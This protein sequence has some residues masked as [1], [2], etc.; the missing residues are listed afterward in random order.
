MQHNPLRFERIIDKINNL[1]V[2]QRD[3]YLKLKNDGLYK[4][5][6]YRRG[7][8]EFNGKGQS[9]DKTSYTILDVTKR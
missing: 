1:Y 8:S 3:K 4:T 7:N 5:V 6:T 2:V 9:P